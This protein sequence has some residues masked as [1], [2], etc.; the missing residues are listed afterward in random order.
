V[1]SVPAGEFS[2]TAQAV[3]DAGDV[4]GYSVGPTGGSAF[5]W[6]DRQVTALGTLPGSTGA[7]ALGINEDAQV[8]GNTDYG[9]FLWQDGQMT[10]LPDLISTSR[11]VDINNHGQSAG[12]SATPPRTAST[13]TPCSGP[14]EPSRQRTGAVEMARRRAS[15]AVPRTPGH[16][17]TQRLGAAPGTAT[18]EECLTVPF[19]TAS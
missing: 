18:W 1:R 17:H 14:A 8:V 13:P 2:A 19:T 11:A 10:A 16:H 15:T 12:S 7:T 3:N 9:A 5:L 4:A 6:R